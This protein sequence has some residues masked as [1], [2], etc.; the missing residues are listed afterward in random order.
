MSCYRLVAVKK[1][2]KKNRKK[3]SISPKKL[4]VVKGLDS[5]RAMKSFDSTFMALIVLQKFNPSDNELQKLVIGLLQG[6]K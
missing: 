2:K 4:N 6:R 5:T 3:Q 1:N